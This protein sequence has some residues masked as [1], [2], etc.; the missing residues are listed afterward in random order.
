MLVEDGVFAN[1]GEPKV[2]HQAAGHTG[3]PTATGLYWSS[4]GRRWLPLWTPAKTAAAATGSKAGKS[5]KGTKRSGRA[6]GAKTAKDDPKAGADNEIASGHPRLFLA[7]NGVKLTI[8]GQ[9][10]E[11]GAGKLLAVTAEDAGAG[12][13]KL[14]FHTTPASEGKPALEIEAIDL[15]GNTRTVSWPLV[16][17]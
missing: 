5:G 6:K 2:A 1:E 13:S 16:L 4:D 8:D 10:F 14:R 11:P 7:A 3:A 9:T 15:V 17:P 12:V